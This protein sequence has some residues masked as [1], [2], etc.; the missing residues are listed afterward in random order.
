[1]NKNYNINKLPKWAK[2]EIERLNANL[3][4]YR[5]ERGR[6][7]GVNQAESIQL[8]LHFSYR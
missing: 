7:C 8:I 4:Y 3:E 5:K 6:I 1:M 2:G